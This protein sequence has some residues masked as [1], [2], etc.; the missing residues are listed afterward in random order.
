MSLMYAHRNVVAVDQQGGDQTLDLR[1]DTTQELTRKILAAIDGQ[2]FGFGKLRGLGIACEG[3]RMRKA[4]LVEISAAANNDPDI[5]VIKSV[6][7]AGHRF[8]RAVDDQAAARR[9]ESGFRFL[10]LD[11]VLDFEISLL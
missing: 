11:V 2:P 1:D 5:T 3:E 4:G 7:D 8:L 10:P 9:L 6:T